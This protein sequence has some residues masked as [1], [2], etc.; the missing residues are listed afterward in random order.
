M[1]RAGK[2]TTEFRRKFKGFLKKWRIEKKSISFSLQCWQMQMCF[3]PTGDG[4]VKGT[5]VTQPYPVFFFFFFLETLQ[6]LEQ[7]KKSFLFFYAILWHF[8]GSANCFF[9]PPVLLFFSTWP[10]F[11]T[12]AR[13]LSRVFSFPFFLLTLRPKSA[14]ALSFSRAFF[15]TKFL[16]G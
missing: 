7:L 3:S 5:R 2:Q 11:F 1:I 15:S 10:L 8:L 14:I 6:K 4:I 13:A 9:Y 16:V 12:L